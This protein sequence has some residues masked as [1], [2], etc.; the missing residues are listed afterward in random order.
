MSTETFMPTDKDGLQHE[1]AVA[2]KWATQARQE[3][4]Q[5]EARIKEISEAL[6]RMNRVYVRPSQRRSA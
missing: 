6:A 1:L 5:A 3:L 4:R 2:C